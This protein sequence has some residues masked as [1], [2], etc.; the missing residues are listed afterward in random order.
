MRSGIVDS[1]AQNMYGATGSLAL[2][3]PHTELLQDGGLSLTRAP[4]VEYTPTG[5][6]FEQHDLVLDKLLGCSIAPKV[7]QNLIWDR[8]RS[9]I[10]YSMQNI[11]VFEELDQTK[12]QALKNECNDHIYEVKMAPNEDLMLAFT[13][14]GSLD[15]FPQIIVWNAQTRRKVS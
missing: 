8:K 2:P 13:K 15:G 11:L 10:V 4:K 12:T 7:H 14:T 1:K 6:F 9:N 3:R 5:Y